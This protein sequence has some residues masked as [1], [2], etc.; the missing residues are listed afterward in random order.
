VLE[1]VL[2]RLSHLLSSL[3]ALCACNRSKGRSEGK[4]TKELSGHHSQ[5]DM[6]AL[7]YFCHLDSQLIVQMQTVEPVR[8]S[9]LNLTKRAEL[10]TL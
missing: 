10:C 6:F 4:T 8:A 9:T 5:S 2:R 3:R 7:E 1:I